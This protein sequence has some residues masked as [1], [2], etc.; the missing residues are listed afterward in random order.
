[1]FQIEDYAKSF[2]ITLLES[3]LAFVNILNINVKRLI[4]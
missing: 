1:M 3:H 2:Y 4:K